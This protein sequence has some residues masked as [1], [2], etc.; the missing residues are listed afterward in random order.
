MGAGLAALPV[1]AGKVDSPVVT[2]S[3]SSTSVQLAPNGTGYFIVTADALSQVYSDLE[4]LVQVPDGVGFTPTFSPSKMGEMFTS[5]TRT[6]GAPDG[7]PNPPPGYQDY[8]FAHYTDTNTFNGAIACKFDVTYTGSSRQT[9]TIVQVKQSVT[10]GNDTN[11][12]VSTSI[13]SVTLVPYGN[14][15]ATLTSLS[16]LSVTPGGLDPVFSPGTL[17]YTT[18]TTID[19]S[20]T[21]V[22]VS[23]APSDAS[24]TVYFSCNGKP[25][26]GGAVSL[27]TGANTISVNVSNGG[28]QS[29]TYTISI[30]WEGVNVTPP[31][32]DATLSNLT[33]SSGDFGF[34]KSVLS[35]TGVP[36]SNSVSSVTVTATPTD[37]GAT[38]TVNGKAY[39]AGTPSAPISLNPGNNNNIT[40]VVTAA[41]GKTT[42][43]Y[44]INIDRAAA[45]ADAT[46]SG[47]AFSGGSLSPA[48]SSSI[49]NYKASVSV[50]SV[51]VTPTAS[52]KNATVILYAGSN[53]AQLK[54]TT[55]AL[56][57]GDNYAYIEV[58]AADG[59]TKST[60]TITITYTPPDTYFPLIPPNPGTDTTTTTPTTTTADKKATPTDS[61]ADAADNQQTP[62]ADLFPFTDVHQS[63]WFYA[64]VRYCWENGLVNGI[65]A[66]TFSP[67]AYITRG[68]VVTI[69]YRA[70][71][72]PSTSSPTS[73]N[74][75]FSDVAEGLW[76]SDAVKWAADK[77]IVKGYPD[78]TYLPN[79]VISRQEMAAIISRYSD[80]AAI[81]LPSAAEYKGFSDEAAIAAYAKTY[82]KNLY[83]AGIINGKPNNM[84]DPLGTA[85]RAEFAAMMNRLLT[86]S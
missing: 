28:S 65:T 55:V 7:Y 81:R 3:V 4:F 29:T 58:T 71:G 79:R 45:G 80:F 69:L 30:Y 47:L 27:V 16:N 15:N 61:G 23:A 77:G 38:I 67:N 68:M 72:R 21:Q 60:Y 1:Q 10:I 41:D 5:P 20:V 49:F 26:P 75:P 70:E 73:L 56:N 62:T 83:I 74:N 36:V 63:D 86:V 37:S 31:S 9:I 39:P 85:T 24:S 64:N 44:R 8:Y 32:N 84:F 2:Y 13:Q 57:Y 54:G 11:Y 53:R 66:T 25:C 18:K 78:G 40:V 51:T 6:S 76:Y 42:Q 50:N 34:S 59:K 52:D 14:N 46:L 82:V 12:Y 48:F 33:L 19:K 43:T 17:G 22:N 35:Y